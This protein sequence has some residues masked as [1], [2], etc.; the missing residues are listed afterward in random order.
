MSETKLDLQHVLTS[1]L[2]VR[3]FHSVTYIKSR[4]H[5]NQQHSVSSSGLPATAADPD[6]FSTSGSSSHIRQGSNSSQQAQATPSGAPPALPAVSASPFAAA[7]E[8]LPAWPAANTAAAAA[9]ADASCS[10]Q[11]QRTAAA[12]AAVEA[13]QSA[14]EEGAWSTQVSSAD[15]YG[16]TC[17]S[18][19]EAAPQDEELQA[20]GRTGSARACRVE[21]WIVQ[22]RPSCL[23]LFLEVL[24]AAS[25]TDVKRICSL[26]AWKRKTKMGVEKWTH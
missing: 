13:R 25:V 19:A 2:Q 11:Q 3:A 6:S 17:S 8:V 26:H 20:A 24:T 1:P 18:S 16:T 15:A 7:Q 5:K 21:T 23:L 12:V 10:D 14:W 9:A 4:Q 22:V